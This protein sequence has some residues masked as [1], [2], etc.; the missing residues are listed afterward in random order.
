MKVWILKISNPN[1]ETI[2]AYEDYGDAFLA[3]ADYVESEWD[4]GLEDQYGEFI[5][6]TKDAAIDLYF[7]TWATALDPEYYTLE[8]SDFQT[9]IIPEGTDESYQER[10]FTEMGLYELVQKGREILGFEGNPPPDDEA[11][12]Y[13]RAVF[14]ELLKRFQPYSDLPERLELAGHECVPSESKGV[15]AIPLNIISN[16]RK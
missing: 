2:T 7:E 5:S 12:E 1:D 10:T 16:R 14:D 11:I 13:A 9:E 15:V 6:L 8:E 3:L 4:E